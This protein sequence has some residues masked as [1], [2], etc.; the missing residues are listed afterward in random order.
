MPAKKFPLTYGF[1]A[2]MG[3]IATDDVAKLKDDEHRRY[4]LTPDAILVF[5]RRGTFFDIPMET[6]LDKSKADR[7]GKLLV[8]MQV[9][10]FFIQCVA[11]AVAFYPLTLIEVHTMVHVFCALSMYGLWWKVGHLRDPRRS[12]SAYRSVKE[13]T[14][15]FGAGISRLVRLLGV[16]GCGIRD[17][18]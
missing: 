9:I 8:C 17:I 11:R 4:V 6:I 12:A 7:I 2:V 10:W 3:G 16:P 15:H 13:T 1:F 14:R 5:A 18:K